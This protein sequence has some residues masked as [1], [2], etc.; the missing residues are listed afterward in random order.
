MRGVG[1]KAAILWREAE[2]VVSS[3]KAQMFLEQT[4][5]EMLREMDGKTGNFIIKTFEL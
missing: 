5:K 4:M 2:K 1:K 3:T